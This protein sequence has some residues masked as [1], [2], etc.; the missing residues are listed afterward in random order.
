MPYFTK[1]LK[2]VSNIFFMIAMKLLKLLFTKATKHMSIYN[3]MGKRLKISLITYGNYATDFDISTI[4][5]LTQ[6]NS[7]SLVMKVYL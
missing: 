2:F 3:L 1:N 6:L 7:N 5:L 4:Y